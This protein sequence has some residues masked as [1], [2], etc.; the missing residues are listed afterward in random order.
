[1]IT[2]FCHHNVFSPNGDLG[3]DPNLSW[4]NGDG[5]NNDLKVFSHSNDS[6]GIIF[7]DIANVGNGSG[8]FGEKTCDK[9]GPL[10]RFGIYLSLLWKIAPSIPMDQTFCKM[11]TWWMECW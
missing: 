11:T 8:I 4:F 2:F 1:M 6:I 5:D 9:V 10:I 3:G 7:G